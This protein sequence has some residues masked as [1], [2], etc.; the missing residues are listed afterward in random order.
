MSDDSVACRR[1][2][3][4]VT[5]RSAFVSGMRLR[6][7]R[8]ASTGSSRL[9]RHLVR[10]TSR[11]IPQGGNFRVTRVVQCGAPLSNSHNRHG[12]CR[13]R[14]FRRLRVERTSASRSWRATWCANSITTGCVSFSGAEV[15]QER[16]VA[17]RSDLRTRSLPKRAANCRR[18]GVSRWSSQACP[19]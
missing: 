4:C 17:L 16:F 18:H 6:C 14:Q 2:G 1:P 9:M 8:R 11:T 7:L 3:A 13:R 10:T 5:C 15:G 19:Q 12:G